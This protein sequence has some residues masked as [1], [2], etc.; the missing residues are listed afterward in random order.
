MLRPSLNIVGVF[1]R[2]RQLAAAIL[3]VEGISSAIVAMTGPVGA[4]WNPM[5]LPWTGGLEAIALFLRTS[6]Q[7]PPVTPGAIRLTTG[8]T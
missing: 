6:R 4:I 8:R 1:R 7:A 5:D 2:S 3:W